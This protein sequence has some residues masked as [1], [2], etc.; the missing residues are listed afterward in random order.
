VLLEGLEVWLIVIALGIGGTGIISSAGGA[1][2]ALLPVVLAGAYLQPAS[3]RAGERHKIRVGAM[4]VAFGNYW[5]L[6]ALGG[7]TIG[8]LAHRR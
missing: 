8:R 2:A 5:S 3:P 6:E 7:S 1:V 4:I